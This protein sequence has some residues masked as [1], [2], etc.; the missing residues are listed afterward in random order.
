M[1]AHHDIPNY[2][3]MAH[4]DGHRVV[5]LGG[6]AGIGRQTVH[7]LTQLGA[8]VLVV[9]RDQA[10]AHAVATEAG[11]TPATCDVLDEDALRHCLKAAGEALG[12]TPTSIVDI[13]GTAWLGRLRDMSAQDWKTQFDLNLQHA[14][15]V[16]MAIHELDA[17]PSSLVFVGSISGHV[18]V[19]HESAYGVTKAALHQLVRAMGEE[20]AAEGVRVNAIAPGWTRTPRLIEKFGDTKWK[21]V[22]D[23]M[24]RG[25]AGD[26]SEVAGPITFLVSGLS[27]YITGQVIV[28]DGG[29]TNCMLTPRIF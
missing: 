10:A 28:A 3:S 25:R 6:G 11:A 12:G 16:C 5:V 29:L 26:A 15:T 17:L 8:R 9:D 13:I 4:L 1:P 18:H 20:L 19:P 22:D 7:A 21:I 27:S 23:A 14:I 24:P 2:K